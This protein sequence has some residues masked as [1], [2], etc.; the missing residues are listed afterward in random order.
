MAP[1]SL[2][3][4]V[5]MIATSLAANWQAN[6]NDCGKTYQ[7]MNTMIIGGEPAEEYAWPWQVAMF[8]NG[9][10]VY[11]GAS[12]IDPWW[13]MT[14]AHCVD[15]CN[16]CKPEAYEFRAGSTSLTK[17]TDV[18]QKLQVSKII[19][20]P[21]F[22][23]EDYYN[24]DNDIALFKM[25]EPFTLTEDYRVNTI[26]LPTGDMN[27]E[28]VIGQDAIV[29]GWGTLVWD[30]EEEFPDVLNE[31]VVPIYNQTQCDELVGDVT[32]NMICAGLKEG[33][34]DACSG[35]SGGPLVAYPSNNT[36]QYYQIG[37]VSWGNGCGDPNSPG[38]YTRVTRYE[39]W[40]RSFFNTPTQESC[41]LDCLHG[42][43][44]V[45]R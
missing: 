22:D 18:T 27:D 35:D 12:L 16:L 26:C 21:D 3:L 30:G 14:A 43:A 2:M 42:V 44:S 28:F 23:F 5:L 6:P 41:K 24:F 40:I 10:F 33:G 8:K 17:D 31:V 19:V 20:H 9:E 38:V 32:D 11:C 13:V 1:V 15:R 34:V 25:R 29:T 4:V 37:V 39:D 45:R 36:D 7:G